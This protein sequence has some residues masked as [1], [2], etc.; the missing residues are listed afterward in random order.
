[1]EEKKRYYGGIVKTIIN[2]CKSKGLI[3]DLDVSEPTVEK[4]L[5]CSYTL[6][7]VIL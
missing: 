5:C 2:K 4:R 7:F 3:R 1:M 6:D